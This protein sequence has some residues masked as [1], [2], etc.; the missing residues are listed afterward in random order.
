M[1][2]VLLCP[3]TS[4]KLTSL[5]FSSKQNNFHRPTPLQ[6]SPLFRRTSIRDN[7]FDSGQGTWRGKGSLESFELRTGIQ[8]HLRRANA[9]NSDKPLMTGSC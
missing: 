1:Y 9:W 3:R 4:L 2:M 6:S 5:H 7:H 8:K